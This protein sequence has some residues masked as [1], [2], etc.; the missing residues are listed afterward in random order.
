MDE[1]LLPSRVNRSLSVNAGNR[2]SGFAGERRLEAEVITLNGDCV[3]VRYTR[4]IKGAAIFN[5]HL[6]LRISSSKCQANLSISLHV[7][8]IKRI[9]WKRAIKETRLLIT[10]SVS[11]RYTV[12]NGIEDCKRTL[13]YDFNQLP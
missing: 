5:C 11:L 7:N 9:L 8:S 1:Y 12:R 2:D 6:N 10:S 4:A 13:S 3:I